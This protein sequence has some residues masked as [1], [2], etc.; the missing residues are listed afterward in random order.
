MFIHL[1]I[2]YGNVRFAAIKL[3]VIELIQIC[4][5]HIIMGKFKI[6][7]VK[8]LSI[9]TYCILGLN[10]WWNVVTIRDKNETIT[11]LKGYIIA[12]NDLVDE[13]RHR[14]K[15]DSLR[16]DNYKKAFKLLN[17]A[18]EKQPSVTINKYI[19]YQKIK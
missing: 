6:T 15:N 18:L 4:I 13:Y 7:S 1:K 11:L 3:N 8:I 5:F 17:N 2:I 16:F 12:N 14:F 10:L 19:Y 9:L